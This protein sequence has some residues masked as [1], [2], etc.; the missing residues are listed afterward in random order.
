MK[1]VKR[2]EVVIY[3]LGEQYNRNFN[4]L[5]YYECLGQ[6]KIVG[7]SAK[8]VPDAW[9]LDGL[10]IIKPDQMSLVSFDFVI[11]MSELYFDDI[12]QDLSGLGIERKKIISY[13]VFQIPDFDF[14][15]YIGL[16]DSNVSIISNN[17]WGGIICQ[18][19]GIECRSPVKN[20]SIEDVDY[21]RLLRDL[22][23]YMSLELKFYQFRFNKNSQ[24]DYPVMMLDDVKVHCNH[25]TD[26][27]EAVEKWNRRKI[28][29]NYDN[30][31]LEMY[32]ESVDTM[33]AFL[34]LKGYK[35]RICFVP[36]KTEIKNTYQLALYPEQD[37]FWQAVNSNAGNG[38]NSIAYNS[39]KLL[40]GMN[41]A[42]TE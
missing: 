24:K 40:A 15:R 32:T 11:V 12:V 35:R 18:T 36:F 25:D 30:L 6:I 37:H 22:K 21:I 5:K 16:K 9:T 27:H 31:F 23:H 28:K 41:P 38:A 4:I 19:L 33:N 1:L 29:I 10:K 17:C 42:R 26:P 34:E 7:V 3:G 39:L 2:Y 8:W 14:H 13:R 20:L